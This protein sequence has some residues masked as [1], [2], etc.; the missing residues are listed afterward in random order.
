MASI[1]LDAELE[2]K[3]IEERQTCGADRFDE[4]WDGTYIISSIANNEHQNLATE[5]AAVLT[6][7][8][9][10]AH[11]GSDCRLPWRNPKAT[12]NVRD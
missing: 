4:V 7:V 5:V 1:I 3:L 9:A 8:I 2:R 10:W 11:L 6:S 12:Q